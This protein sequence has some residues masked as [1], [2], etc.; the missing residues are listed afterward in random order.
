MASCSW[1]ISNSVIPLRNKQTN[2]Q[3]RQ[4]FHSPAAAGYQ[5]PQAASE[6][7]QTCSWNKKSLIFLRASGCDF[8]R[9][10]YQRRLPT[11]VRPQWCTITPSIWCHTKTIWGDGESDE[12]HWTGI[13]SCFPH[14]S[15]RKWCLRHWRAQRPSPIWGLKLE[16]N[17]GAVPILT[18][19]CQ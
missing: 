2:K 18:A 13:K 1:L 11:A 16:M 9:R 19:R 4:H 10:F 12:K 6:I 5:S 15:F 17:S 14:H 3:K 8:Q 7:S